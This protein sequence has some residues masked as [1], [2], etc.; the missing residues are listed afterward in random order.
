MIPNILI[1]IAAAFVPFLV[2]FIWFGNLMYG[3]EKWAKIAELSPAKAAKKVAPIKLI[4][5]LVLNFFIAF[6]LYCLLV[7]GSGVFGMVGGDIDLLKTGTA[8]AFLA[9]Y[10]HNYTSFGHGAFHGIVQGYVCFIMPMLLYV[11]LFERKSTKYFFVY[12]GYWIICLALM[13][14]II[15][16]WGWTMV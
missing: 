7:H 10:G 16:Q 15:G 1:L 5:T 4:G 13:G 8:A 9:E 3:P 6:G 12:S 11:C 14:G 2:G